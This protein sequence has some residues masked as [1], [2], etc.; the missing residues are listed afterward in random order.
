MCSSPGG[1]P[2]QGKDFK[3]LV[4]V[5][6]EQICAHLGKSSRNFY[7][8]IGVCEDQGMWD[9]ILCLSLDFSQFYA[10][11]CM[12]RKAVGRKGMGKEL[13]LWQLTYQTER[14]SI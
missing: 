7:F 3:I 12:K 14:R 9:Q 4:E 10:L 1:D 11:L 5:K 13:G 8:I 6:G 2:Y